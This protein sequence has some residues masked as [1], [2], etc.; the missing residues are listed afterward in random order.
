MSL[1]AR[2]VDHWH[3]HAEEHGPRD[4]MGRTRVSLS[5]YDRRPFHAAGALIALRREM[6]DHADV[7]ALLAAISDD[8]LRRLI[9]EAIAREDA[10]RQRRADWQRER[11]IG[12]YPAMVAPEWPEVA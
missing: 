2:D 10:D 9:P 6:T 3:V 7:P 11:R 5:V 4:E 1:A 12:E 8:E